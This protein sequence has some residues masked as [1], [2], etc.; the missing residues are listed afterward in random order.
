MD[1]IVRA[2][3]IILRFPIFLFALV[4]YT[5]VWIPLQILGS[6]FNLVGIPWV[7]LRSAF[8]NDPD[9]LKNYT[10]RIFPKDLAKGYSG[11]VSAWL[12]G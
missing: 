11:I 5:A 3:G 9:D 8:N 10:Q 4:I 12:N 6:V 2:V 7:F 1:D